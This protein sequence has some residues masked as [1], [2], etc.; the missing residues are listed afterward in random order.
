[1]QYHGMYG[2]GLQSDWNPNAKLYEVPGFGL[3][4]FI[5]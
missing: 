5:G 2:I 4:D 3:L 1:M